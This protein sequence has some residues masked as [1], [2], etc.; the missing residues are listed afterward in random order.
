MQDRCNFIITRERRRTL[1]SA[2]RAGQR[3]LGAG[4]GEIGLD[5]Q[6][7]G[8][9][10]GGLVETA[11]GE[12]EVSQRVVSA[13]I[14]RVEL[15]FGAELRDRVIQPAAAQQEEPETVS[16]GRVGGSKADRLSEFPLRVR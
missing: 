4:L 7:L 12:Q 14:A 5:P 10:K 11:R 6:S 15:R 3:E 16:H 8:E 2:S 13:C 9:L 1:F